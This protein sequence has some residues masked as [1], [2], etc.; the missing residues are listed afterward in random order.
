MLIVCSQLIEHRLLEHRTL[1]VG[2]LLQ[3]LP[4]LT[5]QD[6]LRLL[7]REQ[8][9]TIE[10]SILW[11]MRENARCISSV[12]VSGMLGWRYAPNFRSSEQDALKIERFSDGQQR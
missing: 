9:K 11:E 1:A 4:I 10:T 7:L 12:C 2:R 3:Y 6:H 8:K 5:V